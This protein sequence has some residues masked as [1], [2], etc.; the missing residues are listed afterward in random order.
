[1]YV[2]IYNYICMSKF[3]TIA[4]F[5]IRDQPFETMEAPTVSAL[6]S[7]AKQRSTDVSGT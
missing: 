7:H 5:G 1:M 4:I 3:D 2:Y 6:Y